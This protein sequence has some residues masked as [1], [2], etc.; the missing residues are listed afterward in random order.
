VASLQV[1]YL[2]LVIPIGI[3]SQVNVKSQTLALQLGVRESE[4]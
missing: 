2:V 1:S 3:V 4:T